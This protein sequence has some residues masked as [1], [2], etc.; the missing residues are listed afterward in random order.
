MNYSINTFMPYEGQH[1]AINGDKGTLDVELHFNKPWKVE[2]P[3]QFRL[4]NLFGKTKTWNVF[5]D[6]G[7]HGGA[8]QKLRAMIFDNTV[9]DP[10]EK[11]AG[12]RAGV[13]ASLVGI[14]ARESIENGEPIKI[15]G[16]VKFPHRWDWE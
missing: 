3:N 8:D 2:A 10:M 14:A 11:M 12:S 4:T 13:I 9:P 16:M 15:D 7:T 1:I 6:E 5:N